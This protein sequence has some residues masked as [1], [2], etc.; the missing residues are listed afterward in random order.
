MKEFQLTRYLRHWWWI[1]AVLSALS[2]FGFYYYASS[3]QTYTAQTMIEFTNEKAKE[4][5]YPTGKEIDV[6]EIRSSV[7]ISNALEA[8]G[9]S[10]SVDSVRGRISITENISEEDAAIQAAKWES[11]LSYEFF[12]TQYVISYTSA[13]RESATD[14]QRILEAVIDSYIRLYAEK[15]VSIAKV[16]NS[17]ESLQNLNYDYIEWAE[18]IDDYVKETR[19]YLQNIKSSQ[20]SFRSSAS[21]YSFQDLYN[22]Y[23][24]IYTVYLPS[25]YSEILNHHVSTDP[26][27]LTARFRNRI[28]E[29][30]LNIR[31]S[32]EAIDVVEE[33]IENYTEKNHSTMDYHWKGQTSQDEES[34]EETSDETDVL[35][36]RY[37]LG[38]VYDFE[39][40]DNYETEETTYD[41]VI[42]RYV[43]L[44]SDISDR[45]LDNEYCNYILDAFNNSSYTAT[46]EDID[47]VTLLISQIE[48]RIRSLDKLLTT[49][50]AEHSEVE[51][52]RNVRAL[53]TVNVA[54]N[55]NISLYTLLIIVVFFIFGVAGVIIVGRG[56]D[57]VEYRFYTDPSTG[58][59]NRLRCDNMI[60]HYS[61]KMLGF[62]F[63]C[64]VI[65]LVNMNEINESI[66]RAGGNEVLHIFADYIQECAEN[67]GFAGYNGGLQF[68][69]LFPGCD[70]ARAVYFRNLLVRVVSEFNRGGHGAV[71][72]F[73]L[74]SV[75]AT[76]HTPYTMREL[77]SA[78]MRQLQIVSPITPE[79]EFG[80]QK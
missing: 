34:G 70:E 67:Y 76:E 25:L 1:I 77:I 56:L 9:E 39:G 54:E 47:E 26:E 38:T 48:D 7:V 59:P 17:V 57:F 4:G 15:Y 37:V 79:E 3:R 45:T 65:T 41:N 50:A 6:Q 66:G 21:G 5:L 35:G 13:R 19:N 29:N 33:M 18:V 72:R 28:E 22:E 68:F 60:A 8:I 52:I 49:T 44:R 43:K 32:E 55:N 36:S 42:A 80:G 11:G 46:Q 61:K 63:T 40:R 51:T 24:L 74:S 31:N 16:P 30:N 69:C 53:S 58:M 62:P 73:K 64:I 14:A 20:N 27:M 23:N 12:P 75:T 71:I 78:A 2:G 10:K